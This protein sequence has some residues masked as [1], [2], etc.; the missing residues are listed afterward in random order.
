MPCR[1]EFPPNTERIDIL[2]VGEAPG[3]AEDAIGQP[4]VGVAG[5]ELDSLISESLDADTTYV[6]TNSILCTP[7]TDASKS[8]IGK[9][10]KESLDS[11]RV[12]L[13]S[14]IR[15]T[16][17]KA[18]VALGKVAAATLAKVK[19][20]QFTQIMHPSGILQA[21]HPE[22]EHKRAVLTLRGVQ[23]IIRNS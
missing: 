19:D 12:Y 13:H 8:V 1:K 4:F 11:C 22:L 17:P 21:V 9:P 16:R 7:F 18:I 3:E 14:L 20:A 5:T 10:P 2:F 6:I 23:R 15:L